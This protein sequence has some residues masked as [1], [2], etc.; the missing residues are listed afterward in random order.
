MEMLRKSVWFA[1]AGL[2]FA[3]GLFG[4]GAALAQGDP[5]NGRT[6]SRSPDQGPPGIVI[7][8]SGTGCIYQGQPYEHAHVYFYRVAQSESEAFGKRQDYAIYADGTW[9]G[10]LGV[11]LEAPFGDYILHA[12]CIASDMVFDAGELP[13]KVNDPNSPSPSPLLSPS[14]NPSPSPRSKPKLSPKPSPSVVAVASP[15]PSPSP[16]QTKSPEAAPASETSHRSAAPILAALAILLAATLGLGGALIAR[17][18][19]G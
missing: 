10:D 17:R 14:P 18:R 1:A 7:K 13:F 9:G 12:S 4:A 2:L 16:Q 5:Y 3:P 11:P 6:F 8:V 19:R 15:F